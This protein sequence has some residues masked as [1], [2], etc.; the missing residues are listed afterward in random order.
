MCVCMYA[1]MYVCM[2]VCM[3]IYVCICRYVYVYV[4]MHSVEHVHPLTL[5]Y[6]HM[7]THA[8]AHAWPHAHT[9]MQLAVIPEY[10][11]FLGLAENEIFY[12]DLDYFH[13]QGHVTR[14]RG[15]A[16]FAVDWQRLR[17]QLG[18]GREL[19][20]C[21]A[22]K[23]KLQL[24]E[25]RKTNFYSMKVCVCVC[26]RER[27]RSPLTPLIL[28]SDLNFPDTPRA[29]AWVGDNLIICIK[30]ELYH[31]TVSPSGYL[32]SIPQ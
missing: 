20:L 16:H 28:Q 24:Y 9:H 29:V 15:A 21:V 31:S 11:M 26:V 1:G 6:S 22:T 32:L 3:Y 27:E 2:Y 13:I 18:V 12:A 17:G 14:S 7:H 30:K 10:G 4:C 23:K 8:H 19:R 5:A 25:W